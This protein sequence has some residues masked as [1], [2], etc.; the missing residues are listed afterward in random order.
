LPKSLSTLVED[1]YAILDGDNHHVPDEENVERAGEL[2]KEVLRSRFQAREEKLG[3]EVLR[4]SSIGKKDRQL[5]YASRG[6]PREKL[7]PKTY[8]KFLYGDLIEVLLLF[9]ARE[10]GHTVEFEQGEVECDGVKGHMDA[11]IDGVPVDVKSASSYSFQKFKSGEFQFDDPFGYVSQLSGYA[12]AVDKTDEAA[13]FVNDKVH[14][15]LTLA[16]LDKEVIEGNPPGPRIE[17][18][19][20]VIRADEP[21]PRCYD[22]VPEGKSGNLKL[23]VGCSYCDWKEACWQDANDGRGLRKFLYARGPVWLVKT[24]KEPN[25]EESRDA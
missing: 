25:V 22:P 18:L 1:V 10:A 12:H 21:P 15:D 7:P 24:V 13:F 5:W 19:R 9:L 16:Y 8:L 14:G 23:G 11:I 20:D 4:F 2:F 6:T 3:E 17:R